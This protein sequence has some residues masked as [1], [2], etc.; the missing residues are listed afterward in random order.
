M[1]ASV[2]AQ[3]SIELD[4][5]VVR[6]AGDSGDGMQVVGELFTQSSARVGNDISTFPNFPAEIRAPKGTIAGVSGFQLQFGGGRIMTAGDAP[7]AMV[8][9]NPAALKSNIDDLP[10]KSMLVVNQSAF[11]ELNLKKAG[12]ES[13][14]LSTGELAEKYNLVV[15]EMDRFTLEALKNTELKT[16]DKNRC[17]NFFA[18]GFM[19]WTYNRPIDFVES[20]IATKWA[21]LPGVVD[22]NTKVLNA[23]YNFGETT[24]Q[25]STSYKV[26]G[27][28][29]PGVYRK[30]SGNEAMSLGLIAAGMLADR[31]IVMG[32][33]PI[34][35]A[36]PVL[37][38][39]AKYKNYGVKTVQ[40]EDELAAIG[41]AIG[42]SYAGQIGVTG[43]SGPGISIIG[44]MISL[45]FITELPLLILNIQRG[46][47]STGLPTKT[48]Q[49]DL[50]QA[51][52]GLH[53]ETSIPVLAARSPA[54][55]F[56][57][58]IEA[59]RIALKFNTPVYVLSD[60]LIGMGAEPWKLPSVDSLEAIEIVTAKEGDDYVAYA[61]DPE[62][63]ARK[64]AIPGTPGL[65]HCIGGL[66]K[67][68]AG[69]VCYDPANHEEMSR[70]RCEKVQRIA[71]TFKP[72]DILGNKK[73]SLLIL[74]WG[75][76]YGAITTA[77]KQAQGE[78]L[79]VSAVHL[80]H[81]NPLPNDLEEI[82]K[83]FDKVL[84]PEMNFGQLSDLIRSK[85][86]IDCISF[87]IL[88][89]RPFTVKEIHSK[90][91]ELLKD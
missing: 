70:L 46:G 56:D 5:A 59:A 58:A 4:A 30:V 61:R 53:G 51:L 37:E 35:P 52:H 83:R 44:E 64:L 13:D 27:I 7:D 55:C 10:L 32:G 80:R 42:A 29:E 81:I 24:E 12:Y 68:E 28:T 26:P 76:T 36:S 22:A 8:A 31:G 19:M 74:G 23:G 67:N 57:T 79:D 34:T 41:I 62:T 14:P 6:F 66:E 17:R 2:D 65:E 49:A 50:N 40:A 78:G 16:T 20:W 18:L 3:E 1:S 73:G 9:M 21:K 25:I 54:D 48:E 47:P 60:G 84:V 72:T 82:L 90:I 39:L 91:N 71:N 33:Y 38:T 85:Y 88:Q 11:T 89:G 75:S 77:V 69:E 15:I 86:L 63:L 45:A 87:N 43:T